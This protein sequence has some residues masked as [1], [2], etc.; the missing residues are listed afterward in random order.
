MIIGLLVAVV[1]MW[2]YANDR[3]PK[4]SG[5]YAEF[6]HLGKTQ[7][8]DP[9]ISKE[10]SGHPL[11]HEFTRAIPTSQ[12]M[13]CHMHQP[14]M[15]VNTYL[16]YTMWDYE[17]DAPRMWPEEQQYPTASEIREIN[18]RNPE[19]GCDS[20]QMGRSRLCGSSV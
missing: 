19:A 1:V 16:G 14:N 20:R 12:C 11:K 5:P 3:D 10:E 17:S 4:H 2:S 7:T 6:G 9:T 13:I 15:F 8:V 18:L